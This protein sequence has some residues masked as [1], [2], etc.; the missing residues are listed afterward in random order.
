LVSANLLA[1]VAAAVHAASS[2]VWSWRSTVVVPDST[3]AAQRTDCSRK[4]AASN[5]ASASPSMKACA[6]V[7]IVFWFRG[8]LT[9][10]SRA[11]AGP[12][13]RGSRYV[14]PQPGTS[15]RKVSGRATAGAVAAIVR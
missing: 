10:T 12:T 2:P 6:P 9:I 4:S 8:L 7:S 15:P 11:V 1:A 5:C 14:P 3:D 13:S